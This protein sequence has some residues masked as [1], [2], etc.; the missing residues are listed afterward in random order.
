MKLEAE[1]SN[2]LLFLIT[3]FRSSPN[4]QVFKEQQKELEELQK[5]RHSKQKL[6]QKKYVL[7]TK[8]LFMNL[9]IMLII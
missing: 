4:K 2:I 7:L 8:Y 6:K 9:E 1:F 3:H 5:R